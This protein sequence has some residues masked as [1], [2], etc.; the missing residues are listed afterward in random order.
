[1]VPTDSSRV[2][3]SAGSPA[4]SDGEPDAVPMNR[5]AGTGSGRPRPE[6]A[7]TR[8]PRAGRPLADVALPAGPRR[9]QRIE[10][11]PTRHPGQPGRGV[12]DRGPLLLALPVPAHV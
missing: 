8:G 10:R 2:T 5:S 12:A 4:P 1:A 3:R 9:G 7:P 11:D 6:V